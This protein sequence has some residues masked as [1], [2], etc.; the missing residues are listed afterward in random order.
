MY[1]CVCVCVCVSVCVCMCVCV[2]VSM[3]A[4]MIYKRMTKDTTTLSANASYQDTA[5]DFVH[6]KP[7]GMNIQ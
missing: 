2:C 5:Q 3:R 7:E 6:S 4:P 1:I